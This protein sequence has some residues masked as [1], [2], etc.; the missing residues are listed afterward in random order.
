MDSSQQALRYTAQEIGILKLSTAKAINL[1]KI[2]PH[3]AKFQKLR[4]YSY[5]LQSFK[6]YMH[7]QGHFQN[8]L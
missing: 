1:L 7:I 2:W 8:I 5:L 4:T 6:Q 3:K